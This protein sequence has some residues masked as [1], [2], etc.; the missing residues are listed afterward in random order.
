MYLYVL[1]TQ[2]LQRVCTWLLVLIGP[3]HIHR[4]SILGRDKRPVIVMGADVTHPNPGS[5]KPSIAAV[6]GFVGVKCVV[7]PRF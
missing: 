5:S 1:H 2:G 4:S 3:R 6:S 7:L